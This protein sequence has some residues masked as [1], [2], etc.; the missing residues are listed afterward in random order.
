VDVVVLD[1]GPVQDAWSVTVPA[2]SW[3]ETAM[4]AAVGRLMQ[5]TRMPRALVYVDVDIETASE[6]L[7][8]RRGISSRFDGLSAIQTRTWLTHYGRSLS[9][10]FQ[11]AVTV[12][13]ASFVRVDGRLP[14]DEVSHHVARFLD[15]ARSGFAKWSSAAAPAGAPS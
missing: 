15:D 10:V 1:Q 12:S 4:Q 3:G 11:Y 2:R 14:L 9:S 7:L 13:N 8:Q 5:V 6:R